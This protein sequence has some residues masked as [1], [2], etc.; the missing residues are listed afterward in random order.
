MITNLD[1]S[2]LAGVMDAKIWVRTV[3]APRYTS[4]LILYGGLPDPELVARFKELTKVK[5]L[6]RAYK[7]THRRNCKEHCPDPHITQINKSPQVELMGQRAFIILHSVRPY[8]SCWSRFDPHVRRYVEQP[9]RRWR[10]DITSA[11]LEAGWDIPDK[12][13]A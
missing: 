1:K 3:D 10:S 6:T 8:M 4:G 7:V 12:V 11:M 5:S 13:L 9:S 2:W